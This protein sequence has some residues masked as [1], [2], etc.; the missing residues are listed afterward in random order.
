MKLPLKI[1]AKR[2][3]VLGTYPFLVAFYA[4]L[5]T[6]ASVSPALSAE[7]FES[8]EGY[9]EVTPREIRDG[10]PSIKCSET[11]GGVLWW[12]DPFDGTDPMGEMPGN[13]EADY[14]TESAVV[15]PRIDKLMFY[16]CSGCHGTMV[17]TPRNN[18]PREITSPM[19]PHEAYAPRN[20]KDLKH[21]KGAI[22]CLDCHEPRQVSIDC[23]TCHK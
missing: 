6:L 1:S 18:N 9:T 11:T 7:C 20:P 16:P 21:G 19:Y 3:A 4:A 13:V 17:R 5:V 15:K 22:W 2:F 8:R 12:G 10:W 14:L 23:V